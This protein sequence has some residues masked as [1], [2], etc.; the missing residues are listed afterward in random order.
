[1]NNK[2]IMEVDQKQIDDLNKFKNK[3][4]FV[5]HTG[6]FLII[7]N[8]E[9][10]E[11]MVTKKKFWSREQIRYK[12]YY[13]TKAIFATWHESR[14]KVLSDRGIE[15]FFYPFTYIPAEQ[16]RADYIYAIKEPLESLGA[17]FNNKSVN[18]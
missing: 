5:K 4:L 1:M 12:K 10:K 14:W 18:E 15:L 2:Y 6:D 9:Y 13:I 11:E 3:L 8:F 7:K 16:L 17:L